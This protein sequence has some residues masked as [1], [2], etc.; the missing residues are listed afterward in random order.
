MGVRCPPEGL[1][2]VIDITS[3]LGFVKLVEPYTC[4]L[5]RDFGLAAVGIEALV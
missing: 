2:T 1:E 5:R 4:Q 3:V